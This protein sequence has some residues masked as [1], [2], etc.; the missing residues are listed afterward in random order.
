MIQVDQL[1][2][3]KCGVRVKFHGV[4]VGMEIKMLKVTQE[5]DSTQRK[6][7]S[8]HMVKLFKN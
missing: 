8:L 6:N 7:T 4:T 3:E 1:F 2:L 5:E